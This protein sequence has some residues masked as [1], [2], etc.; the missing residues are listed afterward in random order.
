M[1]NVGFYIFN[2]MELLD[3]A[4][5][6]EVFSVSSELHDY[7]LFKT[8]AISQTGAT[9]QTVNGL[10]IQP[11]YGFSNHP[12]IDILVVP[13]GDGTKAE[14]AKE[15]VLDWLKQTHQKAEY[16]MSVCSGA[17]LLGKLGLL[18]GLPSTTHH[19]VIPH[20][21]EIAPLTQIR[22]GVRYVDNGKILTSAG[23]SA[24][25]DLS[26]YM[27]EKLY[28]RDAARKTIV[29]MEY[30]V[31]HMDFLQLAQ[32][33]QSVRGYR[34]QP[35]ER[36]KL[37]RC[38]EAARLAPSACNSQPWHFVIVDQ[39]EL[40]DKVA[41]ATTGAVVALNRFSNEAPVLVAVVAEP[42]KLSAK[43]GSWVKGK[44]L[45]LIDI[46]I[47]V[48]HFSLQAAAEGLGTCMLGWFD[49]AAV[50]RLLAIPHSKR[51]PLIITVGYPATDEVRAK[52][53]KSLAEIVSY[54]RY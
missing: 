43:L 35:I 51:V 8:F 17:R 12:A 45:E 54:N 14:L 20:L 44:P 2:K 52:Q 28:G 27:V 4:G 5:P 29:Y 23:I 49:E 25:I 53:R 11:D 48:E 13:G 30:G 18:D 31:S 26:L 24:G 9:I 7:Q 38:L 37:E 32:T 36:E 3:F 40:K 22:E 21:R 47:A 33:R 34:D 19:E 46:G 50:K 41:Q 16:T 39:P 6:F 10:S 1:Y 15:E 42:P